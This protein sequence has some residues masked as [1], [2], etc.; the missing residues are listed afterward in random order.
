[1]TPEERRIWAAGIVDGEGCLWMGFVREKRILRSNPYLRYQLDVAN[2]D[3][4][5]VAEFVMFCRET[6]TKFCIVVRKPQLGQKQAFHVQINGI[7]GVVRVL[8]LLLPYLVGKRERA[9]IFLELAR[10]RWKKPRNYRVADDVWFTQQ[11]SRVK[12]M[13][14]SGSPVSLTS[15]SGASRAKGV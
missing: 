8:E 12:G 14:Q 13:N 1:M 15:L 4:R 11:V 6:C 9:I 10:Y 5:I 3:E 2:T 7:I